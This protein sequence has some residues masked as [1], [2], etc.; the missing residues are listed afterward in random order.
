MKRGSIRAVAFRVGICVA[1]LHLMACGDARR[2]AFVGDC[3]ARGGAEGAC[4]CVYDIASDGL[5]DDQF[6]LFA[7]HFL[8]D[9]RRAAAERAKLGMMSGMSA[10]ARITWVMANAREGCEAGG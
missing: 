4:S 10:M 1:A 3:I 2:D 6:G 8:G 5:S 7:A 9:E